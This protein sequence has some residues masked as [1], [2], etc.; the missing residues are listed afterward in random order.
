MQKYLLYV[1]KP[2]LWKKFLNNILKLQISQYQS[3][4]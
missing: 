4:M 3:D 2:Y 1:N